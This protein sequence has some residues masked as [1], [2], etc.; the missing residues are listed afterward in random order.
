MK[1]GKIR[2][3]SKAA[4]AKTMPPK[5]APKKTRAVKNARQ[6]RPKHRLPTH[7]AG[8]TKRHYEL[9]IH[10]IETNNLDGF[11]FLEFKNS[12]SALSHLP[13]DEA[14]KFRSAFATASTMGLTLDRLVHSTEHY[15]NVLEAEKEKFRSALKLQIEQRIIA[16]ERET[17][18]LVANIE[19]KKEQIERLKAEIAKHEQ[20]LAQ[21]KDGI[22][23]IREKN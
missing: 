4:P 5:E 2:K 7:R 12:V 10:A 1:F 20:E 15:I 14:T 17:Q 22:E 11:D 8:L 16:R 13:I 19:A 3:K 9:L 21:K 23:G 6:S 18:Q